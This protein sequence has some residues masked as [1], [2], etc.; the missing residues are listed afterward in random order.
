MVLLRK[1]LASFY[2]PS[3]VT[4]PL[5][6]RVSEILSLLRSS[7]P[8][9]LFPTPPRLPQISPF[10]PESRWVAFGLRTAKVLG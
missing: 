1:E 6:L 7:T 3:I 2:R 9:F 5:S 4:F 8:L 10:S